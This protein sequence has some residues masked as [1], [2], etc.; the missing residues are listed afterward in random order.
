M[1]L[2]C[3]RLRSVSQRLAESRVVAR[4]PRPRQLSPLC[5][6]RGGPVPTALCLKSSVGQAGPPVPEHALPL[7]SSVTAH[8]LPSVQR[9]LSVTLTPLLLSGST[10]CVCTARGHISLWT[11][12]MSHGGGHFSV[13]SLMIL[14]FPGVLGICLS[15]PTRLPSL[16]W[17]PWCLLPS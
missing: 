2:R 17:G 14:I 15:V 3:L 10:P 8:G 5:F 11:P 13:R 9:S 16:G 4:G 7:G 1:W 6:H 12:T